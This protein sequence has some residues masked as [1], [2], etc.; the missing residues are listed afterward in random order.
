VVLDFA[1][2][3]L[4]LVQKRAKRP[5]KLIWVSV[6][7]SDRHRREVRQPGLVGFRWLC[8][9]VGSLRS[10]LAAGSD[11]Q[12]IQAIVAPPDKIK[13]K[14]QDCGEELQKIQAVLGSCGF[15][16]LQEKRFDDLEELEVSRIKSFEQYAGQ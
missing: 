11:Y 4:E 10:V 3:G 1:R 12:D 6:L 2:H 13:D 5:P 9:A 7:D 15:Q 16:D 8:K 14:V